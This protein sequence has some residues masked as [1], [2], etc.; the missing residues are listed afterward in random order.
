MQGNAY[1]LDNLVSFFDPKDNLPQTS[2]ILKKYID[3][4]E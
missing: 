2:W 1:Q 4:P 3:K